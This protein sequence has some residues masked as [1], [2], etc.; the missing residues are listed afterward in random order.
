[1]RLGS[2]FKKAITGGEWHVA[3]SNDQ[4]CFSLAKAPDRQ[5]CADPFV[6]EHEGEHYIFVE[7]YLSEK[8]KGCIGYF[9]FVNGIPVNKGI[10]IENNYHMSYPDVFEYEGK[11]YMIP[12]SSANKTVDLYLADHFPDKWHCVKNLISGVK[13]VDSTVYIDGNKSY[14]I[15]YSIENGY[16]VHVFNLDLK[17]FSV[18]LISKKKYEKNVA[19]PAGRL[20]WEDEKLIR[21]AQD[22][23]C[24]YG[25]AIILYQVDSL[26]NN[27]DYIEHSVRRIDSK[28]LNIENNPERVHQI[29]VDSQ[30]KVIERYISRFSL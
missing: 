29:T 21:P 8:D 3:Y 18:D 28:G 19:R 30:Y 22:C 5:W 2:I 6:F 14:L 10:V 26:N 16:E 24:K 7:Q 11:I 15:S 27:G 9:K 25:E 23:S 13:Y 17:T 1:M 12:E 4:D 20:Y